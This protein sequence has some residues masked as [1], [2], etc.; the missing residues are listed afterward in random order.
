M[1]VRRIG[2]IVAILVLAVAGT[3]LAAID[4][5]TFLFFISYMAAGA[6]LAI[7]RPSNVIGWLLIAIAFGFIATTT[8]PDVDIA[9][10]Q[11]GDASF[12]DG[13]VTWLGGWAGAGTF[14]G[15][16][17][18]TIVFPSGHLPEREGR[19]TSIVLLGVGIALLAMTAFAPIIPV[20]LPDGSATIGVRNP[21]AIA[22]DLQ[23]WWTRAF[24][25]LQLTIV[26]G[27][28][29]IGVIRMVL[30][31]RRAVGVEGLQLRWLVAAVVFVLAGLVLGLS[32]TAILGPEIGG[33]A[34]IPV[35]VAYPT[36]P[37]AV[38][39]AVMRY[40]LLEIDRIISRTVSYA[41]VSVILGAVFVGVILSL[42]TLLSG[43]TGN[44]GIPVA[45]S[46]LAVFA[47]FQPVLHRVRRAVDRRFD[48]ARYDSERTAGAFAERLRWETDMDRVTGDLRATVDGA[49]A[50][51]SLDVWLRRSSRDAT[52]APS[53]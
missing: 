15:Y 52:D 20:N 39:V 40:R 26:V 12:R 13:L 16:L 8:V 47:L 34:W 33:A 1:S 37:L 4:P 35:I 6:F 38:G 2:I 32:A 22:P 44:Q 45:I 5:I 46:T 27:L 29:A 14:I 9:A 41:V 30:R 11:R 31:Y 50:P 48:R 17:A 21:F 42:Q 19:R 43:I 7:R 3:V 23:I 24:S 18:L 49:I 10:L 51:A 28:L 25:D 53:P 36:I